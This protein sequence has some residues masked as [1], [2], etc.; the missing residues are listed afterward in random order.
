[1]TSPSFFA[2]PYQVFFEDTMAYGTHH[3]I[4]NFRFQ[5]AGRETLLFD[6][7]PEAKPGSRAELDELILLTREGYTRNIAPVRLGEKVGIL[8]TQE[9]R[10]RSSIRLCF[11]VVRE[12]GQPVCA[13]Y[14]TIVFVDKTNYEVSPFPPGLGDFISE[15]SELIERLTGPSYAERCHAGGKYLKEMFSDAICEL[16]KQVATERAQPRILSDE[17]SAASAGAAPRTPDVAPLPGMS[18]AFMFPGQG[19][20]DIAVLRDLYATEPDTRRYFAHADKVAREAWGHGFLPLVE[21]TSDEA[22]DALL[23]QCPELDQLGIFLAAVI[24]GERRIALG[25]KPDVLVGH[26]FGELAALCVGGAYDALQGV[27]MVVARVNAL[28]DAAYGDG[29]M[30]AVSVNPARA[31]ELLSKIGVSGVDLAG[32]NLGNQVVISGP[33]ADIQRLADQLPAHGAMGTVLKSRHPFH[34]RMLRPAVRLFESALR[35]RTYRPLTTP[36]YSPIERGLYPTNVDVASVLSSHFVRAFDFRATVEALHGAGVRTFVEC[37]AGA[38]L[39]RIVRKILPDEPETVAQPG[40]IPS[41][42][43]ESKDP[44]PAESAAKGPTV[45]L[46]DDGPIPVAIVSLGCVLP[47]ARDADELW[48]N[49]GSGVSGI[50]DLSILDPMMS[51]DF[52]SAG[53]V[54]PDKAYSLLAGIVRSIERDPRLPYSADE[55]QALTRAQRLLA[56]ALVQCV[57]GAVAPLVSGSNGK[58]IHC[59]LGS[60]ADGIKEYDEA[61]AMRTVRDALAMLDEAAPL[62][63]ALN[64][65]LDGLGE[66][67]IGEADALAPYPTYL[68]VVQRVLGASA[69]V[70]LLDAACAASL[71]AL[72]LG[73]KM[74]AAGES[75]LVVAGGV[76]SPGPGINVLFGQFKGLSSTGCFPFDARADGV[77]FGE[78]AAVLALKRLPDAIAAGDRIHAVIRGVGLASDGKSAS[79]NVPRSEGQVLAMKRAYEKTGIDQNSIQYIEAHGT[80]TTV[81]DATEFESLRT[82]FGDRRPDL[83]PIWMESVKGLTGHTGW[84]AGATSV[85]K[86]AR[87][88][89][90]RRVPPQHNFVSAHPTFHLAESPFVIPTSFAEWTP[91]VDGNPR[92]AGINGFGFGGTNAHLILEE[93]DAAY[94]RRFVTPPSQPRQSLVVV[95]VGSLFPGVDGSI[96]A[97]A[98]G[99]RHF[100]RRSLKLPGKKRLLPDVTEHM[101]GGQYLVAMAADKALAGVTGWESFR[102]RIGIALGT[103]A[104]TAHGAASTSRVYIDRLKRSLAK[105]RGAAELADTEFTRLSALLV[106]AVVKGAQPSNPYTLIGFMPNVASGRVSNLF[107]LQGANVVLDAGRGSFESAIGMARRMLAAGDCDLVLAGAVQSTMAANPRL[108][109]GL[110]PDGVCLL[111][112][113]TPEFAASHALSVVSRLE[114]GADARE[115]RVSPPH[116][117]GANGTGKATLHRVE[118]GGAQPATTVSGLTEIARALDDVTTAGVAAIVRFET[119]VTRDSRPQRAPRT[120]R[121]STALKRRSSLL[122]RVSGAVDISV[123]EA[124]LAAAAEPVGFFTPALFTSALPQTAPR[125]PRSPLYLVDQPAMLTALRDRGMLASPGSYVATPAALGLAD[126]FRVDLSTDDTIRESLASLDCARFDAIIAVKDLSHSEGDSLLDLSAPSDALLDLLFAVARHAYPRIQTGETALATMCLGG[127]AGA[128]LHAFTGLAG[129]FMKA[130]ARELPHG[131]C[132]S[133][134][135]DAFDPVK[136]LAQLASEFGVAQ[137][138]PVEVCYDGATRRYTR[139]VPVPQVTVDRRPYIDAKSV[140]IATGGGRGVTALMAEELLQRFGCTVVLLGRTD[141]FSMPQHVLEMDAARFKA[142]EPEYYK[143]VSARDRTVKPAA[144]R[145]QYQSF[146]AGREIAGVLRQLAT[147]PG[148]VEYRSVDVTSAADVDRVVGEVTAKFGRVDLVMHG[149]GVQISTRLENRKLSDFRQTIGTKIGGLRN[150]YSACRKHVVNDVHYHLLT[151]AFSY[152]GN[153]G[154]PD[155]GAANEALNRLAQHMNAAGHGGYWTSLA[156]LAWDGIGM[157]RGSEYA[158]L[159]TERGLHGI[160]A[161][162]GRS[163]FATLMAGRPSAAANILLTN[164]E[165]RLLS[166]DVADDVQ[167]A[168]SGFEPGPVTIAGPSWRLDLASAPYLGEHIVNGAPT[169]PG[170]FELAMVIEAACAARPG[171]AVAAAE[172]IILSRFVKV[173]EGRPLELRSVAQVVSETTSETIVRVALISDFVHKNGAVLQKDVVHFEADVRLTS[174]AVTLSGPLAR[175]HEFA[176]RNAV[177]PYMDPLAPVQLRGTFACLHDIVIGDERRRARFRITQPHLLSSLR[178]FRVPPVLLDAMLRLTVVEAD[179]AGTAPVFVPERIERVRVVS[180]LSEE[181]LSATGRDIFIVAAAP[182]VDKELLNARWVQALDGEGRTLAL[183]E[184]GTARRVEGQV[185]RDVTARPSLARRSTAVRVMS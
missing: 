181:Q 137:S 184:F 75:D 59:L 140:V 63:A 124:A 94:H 158:V 102:D 43:S 11:R 21:S 125:T 26:S 172:N 95:G 42:R 110:P 96:A 182:E 22:H 175:W 134:I 91:N 165:R 66:M 20:Y 64:E 38:T 89:T 45:S 161:D 79:V 157:T 40:V 80:G 108:D 162:E 138:G 153:D 83:R 132:K 30:L 12:D 155:Y 92:R 86:V 111:A 176:G 154:Q 107:D 106:E 112:I 3:Y 163:L 88:L 9:E 81:G 48:S 121:R 174:R 69:D 52:Q 15:H 99:Q 35:G 78:G 46:R 114:V 104:K 152:I 37:A 150:L 133:L 84:V 149:A 113:T 160:T 173:T 49:I 183:V 28:R 65:V 61:L 126:T 17:K 8:M 77:I 105:Q 143:E 4:T 74:L 29:A 71:Y 145:R 177:D 142:Y 144:M 44:R 101:D 185:L 23:K 90:E 128:E 118:M 156:W 57:H 117:E 85:I 141:P 135:T 171:L 167:V 93:Y 56:N 120:T 2:V 62:K 24:I 76:F 100:E 31:A 6:I 168:R 32:V 16:G 14:Q 98:G 109:E 116:G 36:V 39:S 179:G 115:L 25:A 58:R 27:E 50:G 51:A 178:Q 33:R 139:L 129:G 166:V 87:A 130:M 159:V 68:S 19:S 146:A 164:A 60:T 53:D 10:T 5:C 170:T 148:R 103:T 123:V 41:E 147:L 70:T 169:L 1:M 122:A 47:A 73:A 72:D 119:T 180:P 97:Q 13:G 136:A 18:L 67:E 82:A 55:F 34:S 151:S 127:V 131:V 7:L 54:V